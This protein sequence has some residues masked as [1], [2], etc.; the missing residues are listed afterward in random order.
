MLIV[1]QAIDVEQDERNRI[2]EASGAFEL[3]CE[4]RVEHRS[5]IERRQAVGNRR[6]ARIELGPR[7]VPCQQIERG[8]PDEL[9]GE[10][11]RLGRRPDLV[12]ER[13]LVEDGALQQIHE[14]EEPLDRKAP[15]ER[16]AVKIGD[17][18]APRVDPPFAHAKCQ[19][20]DE[21]LADSIAIVRFEVLGPAEGKDGDGV[22]DEKAGTVEN[23]LGDLLAQIVLDVSDVRV[24]GAA[25]HGS[26]ACYPARVTP[27]KLPCTAF[28]TDT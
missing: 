21:K 6:V 12:A 26:R 20:L 7:G 24:R 3:L 14:G 11:P 9:R 22:P 15:L 10:R 13:E 17:E 4:D 16:G 19:Q 8:A 2:A 25:V 28:R 18:T 27:G 1:G 23:H 5:R